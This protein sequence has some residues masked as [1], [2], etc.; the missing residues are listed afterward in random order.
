M[1]PPGILPSPAMDT[2]T[3][4]GDQDPSALVTAST[5]ASTSNNPLMTP[6]KLKQRA[7][8]PKMAVDQDKQGIEVLKNFFSSW[9]FPPELQNFQKA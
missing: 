3:N 7:S 5:S 4:D 2:Q 1:G 8:D 6:E 9:M